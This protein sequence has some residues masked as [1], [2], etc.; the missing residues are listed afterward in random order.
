MASMNQITPFLMCR[1]LVQQIDF[2]HNRLGFTLGFKSEDGIGYAYMRRENVAVRLL[3][4]DADFTDERRQ[5]MVYIDV[6]DV[7]ALWAEL[8]PKLSDLPDGRVRAPFNQ[9]YN[10]REFH[11]IDEGACLLMFG[12]AHPF[13]D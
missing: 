4:S 12:M 9:V 1:D 6:D 5:Q 3:T 7:D 8:E 13:E 11:V 2:F 10:Q